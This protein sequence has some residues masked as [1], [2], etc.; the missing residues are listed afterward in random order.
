MERKQGDSP[1]TWRQLIL[2]VSLVGVLVTVILSYA[3][4]KSDIRSVSE[5]QDKKDKDDT[6]TRK[7]IDKIEEKTDTIA[8]DVAVIKTT[9]GIRTTSQAKPVTPT[10]SRAETIQP[11]SQPAP[12]PVSQTVI[13]EKEPS[14]TL[15]P[16]PT[17]TESQKPT[18]PPSPTPTPIIF[19]PPI[20]GIQ[21]L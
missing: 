15:P 20:L 10:L 8:E 19:I 4:I 12:Q 21:L 11:T 18:E 5:R 14:A 2:G 13:V 7:V 16:T 1:I 9:L 17:P 3:T 6:E